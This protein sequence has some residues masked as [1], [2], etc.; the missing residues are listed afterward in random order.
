MSPSA[1]RLPIEA[2]LVK[3]HSLLTT[4]WKIPQNQYVL[5]DE[6]AY[7]LQGYKIKGPEM[8]GGHIDVYVNPVTIP[9]PDKGERSIIPPKDSQQ[10]KDW[11]NFMTSTGYG[12]DMLRAKPEFLI[13]PTVNYKL[14]GDLAINL[15]RA[16]EMTK[17]FVEQ[18]IM[19]YSLDD[20]GPDK[21]REWINK[22]G[23]IKEAALKM[24]DKAL[25]EFCDEKISASK[26]KWSGILVED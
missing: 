4:T 18:T 17:L 6:L 15:M 9:W 16:F 5:V 11:T 21:M 20:V 1:E 12:L 10:M 2:A 7:N 26:E 13:I 19:Y 14:Q 23:L 25:A 3:L 22:L 8:K 24:D